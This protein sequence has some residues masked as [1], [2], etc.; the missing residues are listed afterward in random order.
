MNQSRLVDLAT[1]WYH[2]TNRGLVN[3]LLERQHQEVSSFHLSVKEMTI[4]LDDVSCLFLFLV[5]SKPIDHVPLFFNIKAVKI[6]L[7]SHLGILIVTKASTAANA[8]V[9]VRLTWLEDLYRRYVESGFYVW[10]ATT[11]LLHLINNMIF[12]DKYTT[13][14]HVSYLQYLDTWMFATSTHG[15]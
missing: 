5:I 12:G 14:V 13:H 15:E 10:A 4:T 8:G 6:L 2:A 9:R 3:V 7:M 11:Y 1:T